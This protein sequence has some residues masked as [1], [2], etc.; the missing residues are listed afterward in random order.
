MSLD[1]ISMK[2]WLVSRT[3]M[4][5]LNWIELE[6]FCDDADG[7]N[8]VELVANSWIGSWNDTLNQRLCLK[9]MDW[10]AWNRVMID[11]GLSFDWFQIQ[12]FNADYWNGGGQ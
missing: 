5:E 12:R 4:F 10:C 11:G 3:E 6:L 7:W 9:L 2:C 8:E 1:G